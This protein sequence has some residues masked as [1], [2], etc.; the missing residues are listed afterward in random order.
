M[1]IALD[2][3]NLA[4][5]RHLKEGRKSFGKIAEA[6]SITEN[7]VRSRVTK[8]TREGVLNITGLVAP[9]ALEGHRV[10]MIGV[11]LDKMDLVTKGEEI[12]HLKGVVSVCVV[13]GRFDLM[14]TVLLN[15]NFGILE[16]Y[17]EEVSKVEGIHAVETFVVYKSYNMNVPYIL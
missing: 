4:I 12:S 3:I 16:F 17:T 14:L 10:V 6:L 8:L 11:K 9:E 1:A 2:K 15:E 13:T 7:T 5:I